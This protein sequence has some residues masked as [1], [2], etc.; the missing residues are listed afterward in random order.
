[1]TN[2]LLGGYVVVYPPKKKFPLV[3]NQN[4]SPRNFPPNSFFKKIHF[5]KGH[6]YKF[7]FFASQKSE[8]FHRGRR[9]LCTPL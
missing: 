4:F 2:D 9:S 8:T 1:M 7:L 3:K 6:A 5:P